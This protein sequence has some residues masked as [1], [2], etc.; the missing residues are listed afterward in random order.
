MKRIRTAADNAAER[1]GTTIS[2]ALSSRPNST[3]HA[4]WQA[5]RKAQSA[6]STNSAI[7]RIGNRSSMSMTRLFRNA[8]PHTTV[9]LSHLGEKSQTNSVSFAIEKVSAVA[10]RQIRRDFQR[11]KARTIG[12]PAG[13]I[14]FRSNSATINFLPLAMTL[15]P[16]ASNRALT[17]SSPP[18]YLGFNWPS[19][20]SV[21]Q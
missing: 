6:M 15:C 12:Q 11:L 2:L 18:G 1:S 4:S 21:R 16:S 9:S 10:Q 20:L 7:P 19:A 17:F 8:H 14:T 3:A 13:R 5:A